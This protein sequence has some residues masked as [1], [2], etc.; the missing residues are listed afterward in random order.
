MKIKRFEAPDMTTALQMVKAD[1]GGEAVIL[2]TARRRRKDPITG[3][4]AALVEVIAA[5]EPDSAVSMGPVPDRT[6]FSGEEETPARGP[7]PLSV[8]RG[9]FERLGLDPRLVHRLSGLFSD[10]VGL[11]P[12]I[13]PEMVHAWLVRYGLG[14][15]RTGDG[16]ERGSRPRI[17][18]VGPTGVGKTTTVA[19]IAARLKFGAGMDGVLVSIDTYRLGAIQQLGTFADLLGLAFE[20]P[21]DLA[22]LR[23]VFERHRGMDFILVDTPGR[24]MRDP[25]AGEELAA[26]F[27]ALPELAGKALVPATTKGEDLKEIIRFYSRFPVMDWIITKVDETGFYGPICAMVIGEGIPVSFVTNGQRVPDDIEQATVQGLVRLLL[28]PPARTELQD[29]S[30]PA[31]KAGPESLCRR[32]GTESCEMRTI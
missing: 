28:S 5:V 23:D 12:R 29:G 15:I 11:D 27:E 20:A 32:Y 31:A 26:L 22:G 8:V 7:G 21:R 2:D 30:S 3:K 16:L 10:T 1:L 17:A 25:R 13:T 24:S 14:R 4:I 19:K 18:L 9:V 6:V